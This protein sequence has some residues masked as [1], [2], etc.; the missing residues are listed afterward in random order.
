MQFNPVAIIVP[1]QISED[2]TFITS[3]DGSG[4]LTVPSG[5]PLATIDL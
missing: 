4:V 3:Q 1:E 5:I 2:F